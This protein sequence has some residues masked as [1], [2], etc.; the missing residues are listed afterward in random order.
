MQKCDIAIV[1]AGPYGL[2]AAAYLRKLKD[3]DVR[4]F[5]EPMSF[6]ASHMPNTMLLR[7]PWLA[8]FIADPD[9][10]LTLDEYRSV[11][12]RYDLAYPVRVPDFVDYGRWFHKQ[13]GIEADRRTVV[14]VDLNSN[15]YHLLLSDGE[16]VAA[17]RVVIAGGIQP[18]ARFPKIFDGLPKELATH[19]SAHREYETFRN[20]EVL[21]VGAGQSALEAAACLKEAGAGVELLIRRTQLHWIGLRRQWMHSKALSWMFYGR[22]D[23]GPAG[24][25]VAVQHPDLFRQLPRWIQDPFAKRAIRPAVS[26]RLIARTKDVPIHTGRHVQ[27]VGVSG[28]KLRFVLN[29]KSQRVVDHVILGTGYQ[30]DLTR[31]PFLSPEIP[32]RLDMVNGYPRLDRGFQSSLSGLYFLGAPAAWS[33]GP[34]MR[35]VAGT[36]YASESLLRSVSRDKRGSEAFRSHKLRPTKHQEFAAVPGQPELPSS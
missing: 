8:S 20:K 29:D 17:K 31:Y 32:K 4:L 25:S 10:Q 14:R 1:G 21:V 28:E 23:V 15:G 12:Q 3:K 7:S 24:I 6:W 27:A 30:V 18:F 16:V 26:E 33:F 35:F 2:S 9:N 11:H 19:T 5:G 22:A 34:L 36:Y 13:I